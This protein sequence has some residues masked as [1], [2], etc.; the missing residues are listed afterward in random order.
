MLLAP[1]NAGLGHCQTAPT[2]GKN[3]ALPELFQRGRL[4]CNE[5]VMA[6]RLGQLACE[7]ALHAC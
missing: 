3:K 5:R 1:P 6:V 7:E 4:A 2:R